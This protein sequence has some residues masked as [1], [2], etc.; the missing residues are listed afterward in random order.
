MEFLSFDETIVFDT[1]MSK[2][3]FHD[4]NLCGQYSCAGNSIEFVLTIKAWLIS[5]FEMED[6]WS[7]LY[8]WS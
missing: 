6:E 7:S 4:I 2:D 5:S 8:T 3:F 1:K